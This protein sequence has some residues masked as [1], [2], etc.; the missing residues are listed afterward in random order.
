MTLVSGDVPPTA[1]G[2]G[3]A[4]DAVLVVDGLSK[5]Y[6]SLW[7]L[8]DTSFSVRRGEVLGLIGPNGSGKTTLFECLAGVMPADAG[9]VSRRGK[10][11]RGDDRKHAMF[12]VPDG[13]RPWPDQSVDWVLALIAGL[14]GTP[15][16]ARADA[17]RSLGLDDFLGL[18]TGALSKGE[19]KRVL[20]AL[21]L[22]TPQPL[23]LLDEPFD[24]LDLRQ[25]RDAMRLLRAHA[26]R[27]RTLFLSIHQLSDAALIC[28]RL[29]LLSGGRVVGEG[30]L[31]ELRAK[32]NV[33]PTAGLEEVFLALT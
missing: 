19:N 20:L 8:R 7:A 1:D 11:L 2:E 18:Y 33:E 3:T 16:A 14:F 15:D 17:A 31:A 10:Q 4:T 13:I 30:T 25:T 28:D 27:G 21:G 32:A 9:S 12:Y 22:L 29:V 23:L 5:R 24:G 6:G 26:A